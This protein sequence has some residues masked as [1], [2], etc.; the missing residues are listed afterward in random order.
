MSG[1]KAKYS[2]PAAA[3]KIKIPA[4]RI[5]SKKRRL[6]SRRSDALLACP[7]CSEEDMVLGRRRRGRTDGNGQCELCGCHLAT[8]RIVADGAGIANGTFSR[9]EPGSTAKR[10]T[11]IKA[12]GH[13][14]FRGLL[15]GVALALER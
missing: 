1:C 13:K 15:L 12:R 11:P 7:V 4:N 2:A 8:D 10:R 14:W 5:K 9:P 6:C 3:T